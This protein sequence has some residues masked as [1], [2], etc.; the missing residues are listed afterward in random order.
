MPG[1][2]GGTFNFPLGAKLKVCEGTCSK[3]DNF[4][5]KAVSPSQRW[6]YKLAFDRE[7]L[8]SEIF[9]LSGSANVKRVSSFTHVCTFVSQ[10]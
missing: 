8:T 5:C 7:H 9:I 2:S 6:R 10:K 4:V 3:K 1:R